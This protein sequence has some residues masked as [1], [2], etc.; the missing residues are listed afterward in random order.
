MNDTGY[1]T[2]LESVF[3]VAKIESSNYTRATKYTKPKIESR[4]SAC[5]ALIRVVVEVGVQKLR[6]KTVKALVEH[7]IQTLPTADAGYCEPLCRDY[8]KALVC[9]LEFTAHPEHFLRDEWVEL[10]DFC[11]EIVRDLNRTTDAYGSNLSNGSGILHKQRSN[12]NDFSRSASP[13]TGVDRG[14]TSML[15]ASQPA[16]FPLLRDCQLDVAL[17]LQHLVSVPNAPISENAHD[18][19]EVIVSSLNSYTKVASMQNALLG[20]INSMMFRIVADDTKL[21]IDTLKKM[22]SL[23]RRLWDI[24]DNSI[25]ES[26]LILLS[27][28]EVL[29]P[30]LIA[31]CSTAIRAD[32]DALVEILRA[33]Y[34]TRRQREKLQLD[35]LSL[36][37]PSEYMNSQGPLRTGSIQLRCGNVKA[38]QPWSLLATSAS[39]LTAIEKGVIAHVKHDETDNLD[40]PRKRPKL[41]RPLDDIFRFAQGSNLS[42]KLFA[43]QLLVFVF[44]RLD[45]EETC[46]QDHLNMLVPCLSD[47]DGHLLSWAMLA[48]AS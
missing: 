25:K 16:M 41:T 29:L 42:E 17:C 2:I 28:G 33:D 43:L 40:H 20:S 48:I 45:F 36:I 34:C 32:L 6:H 15:S 30:R 44:E 47:D 7:I 21:A 23:F 22:L 37:D 5:A 3:R 27:Y 39:I 19:V 13:S 38:E 31:K 4:L 11:L 26:L 46:L 12:R 10:I 14:R 24:K 1:H 35:D 8:L 18:I 9:L